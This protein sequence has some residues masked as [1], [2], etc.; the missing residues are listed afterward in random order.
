[1]TLSNAR[2]ISGLSALAT[3]TGSAVNWRQPL[4]T[5]SR[6]ADLSQATTGYECIV[7]IGNVLDFVSLE[8]ATGLL[9]GASE[10]VEAELTTALTGTNN[11]LVFSSA[12]TGYA[13]NS[14]SICYSATEAPG[15]LTT[16][17]VSGSAIT[18]TRAAKARMIVTGTTSPD[19]SGTYLYMGDVEGK[20]FY[21]RDGNSEGYILGWDGSAWYL[22]GATM[23][24]SPATVPTPDL[25]PSWVAVGSTTG[26]PSVAPATTCASQVGAAIA[27]NVAASA[28]V[29]CANAPGNNGTG[30]V[31]AMTK[32]YLAGGLDALSFT[33]GVGTDIEG[34]ALPEL[35]AIHGLEIHCTA[36]QVN[37]TQG[38][39]MNTQLTAGGV[40][41]L[42]FPEGN[43]LLLDDDIAL[44]AQAVNTAFTITVLGSAS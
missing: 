25:I 15:A 21:N 32:T 22:G 8:L 44:T 10:S 1:M 2:S 12:V 23:F 31:T 34:A 30:A 9:S 19:V 41:L 11:D 16:V 24:Y 7:N 35:T 28:L 17:G 43:S 13:G 39:A 27:N 18:V 40:L 5:K 6:A 37:I 29:S 26:T 14:T 33:G 4:G 42:T 3:A 36:G 38:V 20:P